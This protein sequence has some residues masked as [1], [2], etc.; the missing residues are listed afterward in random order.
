MSALAIEL[1]TVLGALAGIVWS[2]PSEFWLSIVLANIGGTFL[3]LCV[4]GT[5]DA[6]TPRRSTMVSAR[7]LM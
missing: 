4:S 1:S 6:L 3:Y 2:R 5:L 7:L